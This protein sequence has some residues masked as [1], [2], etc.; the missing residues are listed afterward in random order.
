MKFKVVENAWWM[1]WARGMVFWP[2][3]WMRYLEVPENPQTAYDRAKKEQ[4]EEWNIKLF[5]HELDHCYQVQEHG[6]IR[7]LLKYIKEWVQHGYDDH[8]MEEKKIEDYDPTLTETQRRW[9]ET[10]RIDLSEDDA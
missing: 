1:F 3:V 9:Y 8:P 5:L 4:Y 7:F 2:W 10:G 6:R